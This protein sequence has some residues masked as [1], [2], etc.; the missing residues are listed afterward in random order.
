MSA[1]TPSVA[2]LL[3]DAL[4]VE[5]KQEVTDA[6]TATSDHKFGELWI[7]SRYM[8]R[9]NRLRLTR[10]HVSLYVAETEPHYFESGREGDEDDHT[11]EIAFQQLVPSVPSNQN[12]IPD[13]DQIDNTEFGDQMLGLVERV[14]AL[15]RPEDEDGE[16]GR[17][18]STQS[19]DCDF[20]SL[21]HDPVIEPVPLLST[22]VFS[23]ILA[24][25]Y[26]HGH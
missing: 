15:W 17:L 12:G 11:I 14:K 1:I 20:I 23:V 13:I 22:G 9:T 7:G 25:T 8:P 26:R 19:A 24:V 10:L 4:K 16:V 6:I 2:C 18:R 21:V 3:R 5:I